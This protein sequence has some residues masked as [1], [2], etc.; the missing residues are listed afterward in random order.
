M[1]EGLRASG[2][3]MGVVSSRRRDEY[4]AVITPLGIDEFFEAMVLA[5]DTERHK[6][7]PDRCLST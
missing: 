2:K 6:P 4:E 3:A 1:L 5:E 7:D